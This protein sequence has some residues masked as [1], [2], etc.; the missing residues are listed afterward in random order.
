MKDNANEPTEKE[1][2][3]FE[4]LIHAKNDNRLLLMAKPNVIGLGIGRLTRKGVSYDET[5]I[6][7]YVSKKVPKELLSK[8]DLIPSSVIMNGKKVTVDVEES[9]IPQAQV[10]NLRS[11]PLVGGSSIGPTNVVCGGNWFGT[12]GCCITL[13]DGRTY[14]LSNN[15]VLVLANQLPFGTNIVQPSIPDGGIAPSGT[16]LNDQVGSVSLVVPID[17]G[18]TTITILGIRITIPNPNYVDCALAQVRNGF[19]WGNR[20]IHWIGYP[21]MNIVDPIS[22]FGLIFPRRVCKMGRTSEFTI[23]NIV[24]VSWDGYIDYSAMFC[25][26]SGTN[27]AWFQDQLKVDGG[28]RPFS[29]PGDSGSLV[30]ETEELRPVGLLFAG[31][32]NITYCNHINNVMRYLGI[33]RI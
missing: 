7:V 33:P 32:G 6:K 16:S 29:L 30:L 10:F 12:L 1:R 25:N 27:L 14:I 2:K 24:D 21:A 3:E 31:A 5:V 11:R 9:E 18:R 13:D 26:P 23:G 4:K 28:T 8:E 22:I 15:H 17:F 20:E 19:N